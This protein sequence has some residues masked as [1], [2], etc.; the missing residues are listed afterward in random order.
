MTDL[1]PLDSYKELAFSERQLEEMTDRQ[2]AAV[3]YASYVGKDP[4]LAAAEVE[5]E[6]FL[7]VR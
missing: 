5:L 1:D 7:S 6:E 2:F 4:Y 3:L